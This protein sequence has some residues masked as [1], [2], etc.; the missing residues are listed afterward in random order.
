MKDFLKQQKK[1][2]AA[3][4][5]ELDEHSAELRK[6]AEDMASFLIALENNITPELSKL[7]HLFQDI[8]T[9]SITKMDV[10]ILNLEKQF[11]KI[12]I[13]QCDGNELFA[14]SVS[15]KEEKLKLFVEL[16]E[17]FNKEA[18]KLVEVAANLHK[19]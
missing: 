16:Q 13:T 10:G 19:E 11:H 17:K 3:L 8:K 2:D 1:S 12:R 18:I 6:A 15:A 4:F 5:K 7:L 9:T 14:A